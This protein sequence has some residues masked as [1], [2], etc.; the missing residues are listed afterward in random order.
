MSVLDLSLVKAPYGEGSTQVAS[1]DGWPFTIDPISSV[2]LPMRAKMQKF[3]TVGGFVVQVYGTTWG[4]LTLSGQFGV[5]GWREQKRFLEKM[6]QIAQDQAMQR[7]APTGTGQNFSPAQPFLFRYPLLHWEF[8]CY[9][10]GYTSPDG[11]M[12]V[13]LENQNINPRWTLTLFI[14]TDNNNSLKPAKG[15]YLQRLAPGL[16]VMWNSAPGQEKYTG[17]A[18]DKY[19]SPLGSGDVQ[20]YV[21][22]P[23]GIGSVADVVPATP[24]NFTGPN[25]QPDSTSVT[26]GTV[27]GKPGATTGGKAVSATT[28]SQQIGA[29]VKQSFPNISAAASTWLAQ[30]FVGIAG[31]EG[32]SAGPGM[33]NTTLVLNTGYGPGATGT[34]NAPLPNYNA[35]VAA[36]YPGDTEYSVGTFG[37]N[38]GYDYYNGVPTEVNYNKV[39]KYLNVGQV[40]GA[41]DGASVTSL[42][43]KLGNRF[44][45]QAL[46]AIE[47]YQEAGPS[48]RPWTDHYVTDQGGHTAM[49]ATAQSYGIA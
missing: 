24:S 6:M 31:A 18:D 21:N 11:P 4:D 45:V 25:T 42:G 16:G 5:G 3:R 28:I 9:L 26:G 43:E 8:Y 17:Y 19:N 30:Q 49:D 27:P 10:K 36:E 13:H 1:I 38:I 40:N 34:W 44:D 22:S 2:Q 14:V 41:P 7:Q 29:A 47:I 37:I 48:F 39:A 32:G 23:T 46:V 15:A 20:N 33:Y 35:Q 12:A